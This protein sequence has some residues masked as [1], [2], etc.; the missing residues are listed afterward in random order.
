MGRRRAPRDARLVERR[1]GR[2][3]ARIRRTP[4]HR[5]SKRRRSRLRHRSAA[6]VEHDG[7]RPALAHSRRLSAADGAAHAVAFAQCRRPLGLRPSLF[8]RAFAAGGGGGQRLARRRPE[9]SVRRGF[10]RADLFRIRRRRRPAIRP[11]DLLRPPAL[12][13][14]RVRSIEA[15]LEQKF[16]GNRILFGVYRVVVDEH[17]RTLLPLRRR[18]ERARGQGRI[19]SR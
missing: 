5:A 2:H 12:K 10:P 4:A 11:T 15:S 6:A 16:G 9:D 19:G 18:K 8:L 1:Q 3:L 13:P 17:G 7:H 14:E